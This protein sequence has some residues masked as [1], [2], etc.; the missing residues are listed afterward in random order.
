VI[1]SE[2]VY[3]ELPVVSEPVAT[4]TEPFHAIPVPAVLKADTDV[5]D[6]PSELYAIVFPPV[7]VPTA[8]HWVPFHATPFP[9]VSNIWGLT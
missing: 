9:A 5:H 1:P 4:H 8:I 2:L 7:S 6:E 3:R